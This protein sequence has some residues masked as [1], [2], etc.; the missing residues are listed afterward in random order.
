MR[1]RKLS[2]IRLSA[3]AVVPANTGTAFQS[4]LMCQAVMLM[5]SALALVLIERGGRG[6]K[7]F[8]TIVTNQ[9]FL[10]GALSVVW[11]VSRSCPAGVG[12]DHLLKKGA[13]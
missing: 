6:R 4:V 11:A 12:S 8:S 2:A 7:I 5:I 10:M 9:V 13:G 3:F 1:A